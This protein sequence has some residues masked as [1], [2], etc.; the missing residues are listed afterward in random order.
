[1]PPMATTGLPRPRGISHEIEAA[2]SV[3]GVF[4]RRQE[5]GPDRDVA[6][7]AGKRL[8]D[9]LAVVSRDAD[10]AFRPDNRTHGATERSV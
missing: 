7:V 1:M 5:D 4:R 10:D 2:G 6:G 8:V 9:L 3:P